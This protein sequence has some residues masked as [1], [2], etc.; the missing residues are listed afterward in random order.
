MTPKEW[1]VSLSLSLAVAISVGICD[2]QAQPNDCG[3]ATV[4]YANGVISYS[5]GDATPNVDAL[6]TALA[7]RLNQLPTA[8][9]QQIP[10]F[11]V[12]LAWVPSATDTSQTNLLQALYDNVRAAIGLP[13]Y[14]DG[15]ASTHLTNYYLPALNAGR[16][17]VTVSH[18]Y[19]NLL[20]N[21]VI[22]KLVAG[23]FADS[24]GVMAVANVTTPAPTANYDYVTFTTDKAIQA[25]AD[26]SVGPSVPN[27]APADPAALTDPA[28][29]TFLGAYMQD[30]GA[31]IKI[32]DTIL[33]QLRTTKAPASCNPTPPAN[34]IV[35]DNLGDRQFLGLNYDANGALFSISV[36]GEQL[37]L[38]RNP[39]LGNKL[40]GKAAIAFSTPAAGADLKSIELPIYIQGGTNQVT[41]SVRR[42]VN[43]LPDTSS[44]LAL[45]TII[46]TLKTVNAF[47]TDQT[48]TTTT[49][50]YNPGAVPLLPNTR[51]WIEATAPDTTVAIWPYGRT[52]ASAL[53][54]YSSGGAP[55]ATGDPPT[56][57]RIVVTPK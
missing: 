15:L 25:L 20:T 43:G 16:R 32:V 14:A 21:Q 35:F 52:S 3:K 1:I 8:E 48:F 50:N 54:A 49:V 13:S 19:G 27:M 57:V 37:G 22:S 38:V 34:P 24:I 47:F 6:R 5:Q 45:D 18:S 51:Y 30:A 29:H 12:A 53:V 11:D 28:N 36:S 55:Y 39:I 33:R 23:G 26:L 2:A 46:G 4:L 42:D 44:V 9:R 10:P 56:A 17:V 41:L 31:E 7:A 40:Q